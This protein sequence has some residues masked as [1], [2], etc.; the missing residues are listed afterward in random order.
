MYIDERIEDEDLA[1]EL[2]Y[3]FKVQIIFRILGIQ[4]FSYIGHQNDLGILFINDRE[5]PISLNETKFTSIF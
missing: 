4:I 1:K 5:Y 2:G 3:K